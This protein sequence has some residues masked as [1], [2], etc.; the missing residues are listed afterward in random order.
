METLK[1]YL[2]YYFD[3]NPMNKQL[4]LIVLSCEWLDQ[5]MVMI[6]QLTILLFVKI[7][8]EK[9]SLTSLEFDCYHQSSV[10]S[11]GPRLSKL[12]LRGFTNHP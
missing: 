1:R 2:E 5:S 7:T 6:K 9:Y 11:S 10:S 8:T 12:H 3:S 4:T